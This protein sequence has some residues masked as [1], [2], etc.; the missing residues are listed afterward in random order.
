MGFAKTGSIPSLVAG[1][2][3]VA[4]IHLCRLSETDARY[5]V[6]VSCTSTAAVSS[7]MA[8]R[9]GGSTLLVRVLVLRA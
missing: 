9:T 7:A 3:Y 1:V 6:L 2:G 8:A 4:S 5:I